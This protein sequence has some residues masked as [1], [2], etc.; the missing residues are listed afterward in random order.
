MKILLGADPELFAFK[1]SEPISVHNLLE[2]DKKNPVKVFG[3]AVQVDGTAAEFNITPTDDADVFVKRI[4][5]VRNRI[6]KIIQKS[7][8]SVVLKSVP[9]V[10]FSK[11]YWDSIPR[12]NKELGCDPDFNAYSGLENVIVP[13][14]QRTGFE[15]MRTGSGHIH[16][17]WRNPKTPFKDEQEKEDHFLTCRVITIFLD[18]LILPYEKYWDK[19]TDRRKLYGKPGAF[20]PK[21]YGLEYR[22]LSNA[23]VDRPEI[24]KLLFRAITLLLE[25]MFS[26]SLVKVEEKSNGELYVIDQSYRLTT[27][28]N[29]NYGNIYRYDHNFMYRGS[30]ANLMYD[31]FV[32]NKR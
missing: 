28:H 19:G 23:W 26:N 25:Q 10:R 22:V 24:A 5:G 32:R 4:S 14:E 2:G 1:G 3:G 29:P 17:G 31:F 15:T 20:R 18:H 16:I 13:E 11:E 8:P 12:L 7:D 6:E 21:P 27:W 9:A 30:P